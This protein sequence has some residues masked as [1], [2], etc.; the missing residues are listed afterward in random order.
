[1]RTVA[2]MMRA[3]AVTLEPATTLQ[4]A[5]ARMLDAAVHAAVVVDKGKVRGL[6]TAERLSA[7]LAEGYD[8]AE[9]LVGAVAEA[10]PPL[11]AAEELLIDAHLRMR[12]QDRTLVPVVADDGRPVGI[13][14]DAGPDR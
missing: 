10:D 14:E 9:T 8:P 6:L 11:V 12:A 4:E 5:S 7:A 2:D 3:P 13:L 1:M